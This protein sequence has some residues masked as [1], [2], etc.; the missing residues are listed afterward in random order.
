MS[1]PEIGGDNGRETPHIDVALHHHR[2]L[3]AR[4]FCLLMIFISLVCFA[5][6]IAFAFVGAWP[7]LGFFGL[8]VLAIYIAFRLSYQRARLFETLK[9]DD[10]TLEVRRIHP[11]GRAAPWTGATWPRASTRTAGPWR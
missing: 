10:D 11:N 8:D 1:D 2:S 5:A 4:G 3:S 6:G 9:L 7:V